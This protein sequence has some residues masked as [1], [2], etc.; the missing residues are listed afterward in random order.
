MEGG[1]GGVYCSE[2]DKRVGGHLERRELML[3]I[4]PPAEPEGCCTSAALLPSSA[5]VSNDVSVVRGGRNLHATPQH[6]LQDLLY[7]CHHDSC[8]LHTDVLH[9]CAHCDAQPAGGYLHLSL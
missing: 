6:L 4:F 7:H 1:D 3:N 5:S 8:A 9:Q 2:R